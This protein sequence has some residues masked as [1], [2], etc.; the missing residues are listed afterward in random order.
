[1]RWLGVF[2][3]KMNA[4]LGR[5][6]KSYSILF[7]DCYSV[8]SSE[9]SLDEDVCLFYMVGLNKSESFEPLVGICVYLKEDGSPKS[10][11]E[12]LLFIEGMV[13]ELEELG[14]LVCL[15]SSVHRKE[16]GDVYFLAFISM[17]ID[18]W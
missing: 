15:E 10:R 13:E 5:K 17:K 16:N 14:D 4:Y 18:L 8:D 3:K 9:L 1:M 7:W 6:R 11:M 2:E 12:S